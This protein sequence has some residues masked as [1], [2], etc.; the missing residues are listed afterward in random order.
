MQHNLEVRIARQSDL[1]QL[2]QLAVELFPFDYRRENRWNPTSVETYFYD[3]LSCSLASQ[4]YV[5]G[6]KDNPSEIVGFV[7]Y[8]AETLNGTV[9]AL[10]GGLKKELRGN[11]FHLKR[12]YLQSEL[13]LCKD[14]VTRGYPVNYI[15]LNTGL[16]NKAAQSFFK[17]CGY[18]P[19]GDE[20]GT[21]GRGSHE[22]VMVKEIHKQDF[23][24]TF[25]DVI[26]QKS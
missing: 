3:H 25:S 22:I 9:L 15:K 19:A 2:V 20:K 21:Y 13:L 17:L 5:A 16:N 11:P 10:Q 26:P 14:F 7:H 8:I 4:I 1:Q 12:L 18:V 24:A 23:P 6:P